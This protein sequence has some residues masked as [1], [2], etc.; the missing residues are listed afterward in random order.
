MTIYPSD[1]A[2]SAE[3]HGQNI[4]Y[5]TTNVHVAGDG[6]RS[7]ADTLG[8]ADAYDERSLHSEARSHRNHGAVTPVTSVS[9][10]M[11]TFPGSSTNGPDPFTITFEETTTSHQVEKS[12]PLLDGTNYK[13]VSNH[14]THSK[15]YSTSDASK[16]RNL[17][18]M[19]QNG[20]DSGPLAI[21]IPTSRMEP[22]PGES[23]KVALGGG[24]VQ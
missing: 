16:D 8:A 2:G 10:Q 13:T 7:A 11:V 9:T 5:H 22:L 12:V 20:L 17:Q 15:S 18:M 23:C 21:D 3:G 24:V 1:H 19:L 6:S 4:T 14:E